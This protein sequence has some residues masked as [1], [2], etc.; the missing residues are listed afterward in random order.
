MDRRNLKIILLLLAVFCAFNAD[1]QEKSKRQVSVSTD[2]IDWA[3]FGTVNIEAGVSLHQH[4][5]LLAGAKYNPWNF[6][7]VKSDLQLY[8]HQQ[9]AYVGVRY[10]PW[11]VYSGWWVSAQAQYSKFEK[12]GIWRHALDTGSALGAG[13]SL[14][15]TLMLHEKLNLEFGAGFW[16]GNR[17]KHVLYC[18]PECMDVRESSPTTFVA[19]NDISVAVMYVF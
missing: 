18:C 6:R 19:L 17:Y 2:V 12:T 11:Y 15:Y 4:F 10:W 9:T 16:A 7:T 3:N 13:V 14:G 1:A 8:N 5:S